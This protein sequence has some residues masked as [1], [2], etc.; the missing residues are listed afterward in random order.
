ME[1]LVVESQVYQ[2]RALFT[3]QILD[4]SIVVAFVF[5]AENQYRFGSHALQGI[6][7]GVD[8]R[9]FWVID[10]INAADTRHFF[11]PMFHSPEVG[12][13]L[14]DVLFG[15]AGQVCRDTGS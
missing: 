8:I 12:E 7:A 5:A 10:K 2:S 6:P 9:R 11:Q 1:F 14:A 15:N 4:L 13:S 3:Y